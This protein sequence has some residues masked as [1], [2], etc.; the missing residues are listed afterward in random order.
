MK[1]Y[2]QVNYDGTIFQYSKDQKEGYVEF[3]NSKG[4]VS[5]RKYFN[6]GVEGELTGIFKKNNEHINN[7][8]EVSLVLQNGED[9]NILTFVVLNQDGN[10]VDEY[11]EALAFILPRM[12]KGTRYNVNNWFMKKGDSINGEVVKYNNKG[13]TVKL[14]GNKLK[15]E[16]TFE[17]IK[18][19]GT[20]DEK[21]VPGD[22]P[23][24]VWE[25]IAGSNRPSAVSKENRLKF[26]YGLLESQIS[27]ISGTA[28]QS[29]DVAKS[30]PN[31]SD[32]PSSV[33]DDLPF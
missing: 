24:L 27:R 12:N 4:K 11:T 3:K 28:E 33:P 20:V 21:H 7:R 19:R 9:E 17:H 30:M 31:T 23:M 14:E 25:N 13:V 18:N 16:L 6:K 8:Q 29:N 26:S 1:N 10:Q 32:E 22:V 5:Y 15:T 2:L